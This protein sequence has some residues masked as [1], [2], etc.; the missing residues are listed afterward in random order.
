MSFDPERDSGPL[1][2]RAFGLRIALWYATL[3]I[4]GSIAIVL[5][6]YVLTA[7]SLAQ[8]DRQIINQKVGEYAATYRRG[9]LNLLANTVSAEQRTAPERL[10]VRVVDG[11]AEA[12]VLS[13]PDGWNPEQLETASLRMVDG[14][15]VQVGKSTE[16]REDLLARFRAVLGIVTLSIVVIALTGGYLVTRSAVV[17]IRRLTQTVRRIVR[18]GRID[19]RVPGPAGD[20]PGVG[21]APPGAGGDDAIEE[22]TTLFNAMLDRIERLVTAMRGS[23]DNVSHDLR[24]PL[25]RLRGQAEMALAGP[26]DAERY[27]EA[28]ADCVEEADRVLV[29]LNTLMD[30]SEA[31]SGAM[32]LQRE[33]VRL[34]D[35]VMRAAELYRDVADAKGVDLHVRL[36]PGASGGSADV[37]VSGDRT[38]LEQV[39]ANLIDNAVKYTSTGGRVDVEV[40]EENDWAVLSVRDTGAGI[41]AEELPRIWDRLFRGDA[42][43]AE[44]GLGLGLSLVRAIVVAH[45]GTV[46]VESEP[47]SGST[48]IVRL[49]RAHGSGLTA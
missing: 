7:T 19:E 36:Q 14:T 16:A 40:R 45:N 47:G 28:L 48:F 9:G 4:L 46:D 49:K 30:I 29:M 11:G 13:M 17:P 37:V 41:P 23:L 2:T 33:P 24:T 21:A 1:F 38:R 32:Q 15:L 26:P 22:L 3:F 39:A 31:E 10:F 12:I 43:R 6:T 44:R 8:R 35:V 27:R 25:T 34:D 20:L 5:L 42:S 18:T